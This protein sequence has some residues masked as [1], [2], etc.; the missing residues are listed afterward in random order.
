MT[1]NSIRD[2]RHF[3]LSEDIRLFHEELFPSGYAYSAQEAGYL[4]LQWRKILNELH[5]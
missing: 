2:F 5:Y 4:V 3:I 1:I